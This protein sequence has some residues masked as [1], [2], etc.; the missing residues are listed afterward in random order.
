MAHNTLHAYTQ[1]QNIT[2][3]FLYVFFAAR[4]YHSLWWSEGKALEIINKELITN[5]IYLHFTSLFR[6]IMEITFCASLRQTT[7]LHEQML[8]GLFSQYSI[9]LIAV[10]IFRFNNIS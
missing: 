1:T 7:Y 9:T 2:S 4:Y 10:T 3:F 5:I 6:F 8:T